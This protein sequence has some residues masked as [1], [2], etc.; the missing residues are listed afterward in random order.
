MSEFI[1]ELN[2]LT[3]R[4]GV[5]T[6]VDQVNLG[7]REGE[8]ITLLGPSGCGKTTT[9]RMIGGF[10]FPD[11]GDVLLD[12][13]DVTGLAPYERPVNM[14]FQDYALFPH[15]SVA[16][17]IGY[18]LDV[19]GVAKGE[20]RNRVGE[21]LE[22]V[23][24]ADKADN[25]PSQLSNGQ[26]Q[27][28]ALARALIRHPR[29]LLLDEPLSALDLKL[30][31]AM[32]VELKHLHERLG[33]TFIMVTHDQTEA[34]VMSDRIVVM[35]EGRIEQE[36]SPTELYEHPQTPFVAN[37]IGTSNQLEARVAALNG[38]TAAL[39]L[40]AATINTTADAATL[41]IGQQVNVCIRP[42]KIRLLS[43]VGDAPSHYS[44]LAGTVTEHLFHGKNIRLAV[45]VSS[46]APVLVDLQLGEGLA[47]S[48]LPAPGADV[49]LGINPESINVFPSS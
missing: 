46:S 3:K 5:L 43:N 35:N 48:T 31:E 27:R 39:E 30:R 7:V 28:V 47:H 10:E 38:N 22:M 40:G 21:S 9:L 16:A 8:F 6:A 2:N 18:G 1:V 14:V 15:M 34:L 24:L 20:I 41:S 32:Q 4:F 12:G 36:G 26:R 23:G 25:R 29:V 33:L 17:N 45:D 37:F 49:S 11:E 13:G 19:A 44:V 42:E